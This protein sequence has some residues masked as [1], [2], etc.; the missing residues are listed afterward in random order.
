[1]KAF[2][3]PK[4]ISVFTV[5]YNCS[6]LKK[7]EKDRIAP[8]LGKQTPAYLFYTH[9]FPFY[10]VPDDIYLVGMKV[11]LPVPSFFDLCYKIFISLCHI[12]YLLVWRLTLTMSCTLQW[13]HIWVLLELLS[14]YHLLLA[15][16]HYSACS[17]S[18]DEPVGDS[19][20][21]NHK[22]F[23]RAHS[24]L[25]IVLFVCLLALLIMVSALIGTHFYH[26]EM[27][28]D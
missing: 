15:V 25:P 13:F 10:S 9:I 24:K 12:C 1:M 2:W 3:K 28:A 26:E 5:S 19:I 8:S 4:Y 27:C 14:E 17:S 18:V 21:G 11:S 16:C 20:S 22:F 23:V 6:E 7:K